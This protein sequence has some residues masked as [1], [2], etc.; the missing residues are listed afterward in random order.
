MRDVLLTPRAEADLDAAIVYFAENADIETALRFDYEA[1]SCFERL[2]EMPFVGSEHEYLNSKLK[3]LRMWFVT[4][5]DHYLVF[6]L[7]LDDAIRIVRVLH[8][9][10][11]IENIIC[12]EAIN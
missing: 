8:S 1:F 4:N 2:C 6:Y 3:G 12:D 7:V 11:D 9:S 5:F 10:R